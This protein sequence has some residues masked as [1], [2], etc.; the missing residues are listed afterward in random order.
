[1]IELKGFS[2][3]TA[4]HELISE[5]NDARDK[6]LITLLLFIDFRKAFDLV[7][8]YLLLLKLFHYG[9]SNNALS[10][11]SNYFTDRSQKVRLRNFESKNKPT[12]LGVPQGSSLGPIFFLIFIN[13]LPFFIN[14]LG[15]KLFADDTT[16]YKTG[17]YIETLILDF[18]LLTINEKFCFQLLLQ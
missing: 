16:L 8:P 4:L 17:A 6:R 1:M 11:L 18:I 7:D 9:F 14:N 10:L 12:K 3:E 13:D 15:S 2:C 5:I